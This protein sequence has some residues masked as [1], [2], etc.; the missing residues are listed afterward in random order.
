WLTTFSDLLEWEVERANLELKTRYIDKNHY[1]I[2]IKNNGSSDIEDAGV[3][4]LLQDMSKRMILENHGSRA[5][6]TFD[7]VKGMYFMEVNSIGENQEI[8]FRIAASM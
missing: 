3:W 2:T 7:P 5:K 8:T 4:I 6:L 1:E